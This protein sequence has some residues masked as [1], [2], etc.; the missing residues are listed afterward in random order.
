MVQPC[1]WL[2]GLFPLRPI[3]RIG[4]RSPLPAEYGLRVGNKIDERWGPR[5]VEGRSA[6]FDEAGI[7]FRFC[8]DLNL[9]LHHTRKCGFPLWVCA[10]NLTPIELPDEDAIVNETFKR[11][12]GNHDDGY[13][14]DGVGAFDTFFRRCL[15]RTMESLRSE[16]RKHRKGAKKLQQPMRNNLSSD[17]LMSPPRRLAGNPEK[18]L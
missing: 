18:S 14:W 6:G 9:S 4:C 12:L 8:S 7:R 16:E 13:V 1:T 10:A 17:L 3:I 2:R 5:Y 11:I 15:K